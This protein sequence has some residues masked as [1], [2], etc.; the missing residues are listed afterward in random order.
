MS[1]N[2]IKSSYFIRILFPHL[3]EEIKLKMVKYNKNYQHL[4][5]INLINYKIFSGRFIEYESN[6]KVRKYDSYDDHLVYEGDYLNGKWN[7]KGKE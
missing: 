5:N 6:G 2:D 1:I 7:G 3:S 4:R